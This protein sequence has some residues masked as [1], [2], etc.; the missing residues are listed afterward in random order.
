[1]ISASA[2][3]MLQLIKDVLNFSELSKGN[4]PMEPVELNEIVD[5][6]ISDFE[7]LIADTG[8]KITGTELPTVIANPLQMHQLFSNLL[9]Q[10][11]IVPCTR[12]SFRNHNNVSPR[13][14]H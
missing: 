14:R 13:A 1:V 3:R 2:N 5:S 6:I 10:F 4:T 8:A 7:L 11:F 9:S 12:G